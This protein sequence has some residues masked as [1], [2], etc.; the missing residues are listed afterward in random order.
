MFGVYL[1]IGKAVT[2]DWSIFFVWW[3]INLDGLFNA[4]A[5]LVEEHGKDG[6]RGFILFT[7]VL[8]QKYT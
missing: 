5:I 4:K 8:F 1:C 2:K 6:V 7:R 3:H